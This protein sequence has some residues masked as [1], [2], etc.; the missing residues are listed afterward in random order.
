MAFNQF[1][2]S[3]FHELN[4]DWILDQMQQLHSNWN[5]F[6]ALNKITF[7]GDWAIDKQYPAWSVVKNGK[8][9]YLSIVNVPA[10]VEITNEKYWLHV[11]DY[12]ELFLNV[13]RRLQTAENTIALLQYAEQELLNKVAGL[14]KIN[15]LPS[16]TTPL[17]YYIDG[18]NGDDD[19][20]GS[21]KNPWRTLTPLIAISN[22]V[23]N[24]RSDVRCYFASAGVY[25][26]PY[27]SFTGIA[28]HMTGL[29]DGV[30]V[31][32]TGGDFAIYGGHFN[33]KNLTL[34]SSVPISLETTVGVFDTVTFDLYPNIWG[35]KCD[36]NKCVFHKGL[37]VKGGYA[38]LR[39]GCIIDMHNATDA[40]M[41]GNNG[42]V[43]I[44]N[45]LTIKNAFKLFDMYRTQF[46][47]FVAPI[48]ENVTTGASTFQLC[49]IYTK[50]S[51]WNALTANSS[52]NIS[53]NA[54]NWIYTDNTTMPV[55]ILTK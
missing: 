45:S 23:D 26:L 4:L 16:D 38:I 6:T 11:V 46:D 52:L 47:M 48:F 2:Y 22:K 33:L 20:D 28:I 54:P 42:F 34:R 30:V 41:Y 49:N 3:N 39:G 29:V 14:T 8:M 55:K 24:G 36:F 15:T 51:W 19:S 37:G 18:M 53:T 7:R 44:Y 1:P 27:M 43:T 40:A 25:D 5:L 17:R 50:E 12:D 13:E 35:G 32:Q 9:G 31:N 21:E 10:G